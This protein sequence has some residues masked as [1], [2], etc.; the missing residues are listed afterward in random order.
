MTVDILDLDRQFKSILTSRDGISCFTKRSIFKEGCTSWYA[1]LEKR[2]TALINL[3]EMERNYDY[4]FYILETWKLIELYEK[5]LEKPLKKIFGKKSNDISRDRDDVAKK[6]LELVTRLVI[7]D[8]YPK[9]FDK[10]TY[11]NTDIFE[12]SRCKSADLEFDKECDAFMACSK[13]G[14]R[15]EYSNIKVTYIDPKRTNMCQRSANDKKSHFINCFNQWAGIQKITISQDILE[16]IEAKLDKYGALNKTASTRAEKFCRVTKDHIKI[17][18]K[19]L[20]LY[21]THSENITSIY[22]IITERYIQDLEIIRDK[23]LQDFDI[24]NDLYNRR[25]SAECSKPF[26]YQHLLFQFLRRHGF[27]CDYKDFKFLKT[28][29]RKKIHEEMYKDI[30]SEL[31]WNYVSMF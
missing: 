15:Q 11:T 23:V 16:S 9:R 10:I 2:E 5:E 22:R 28:T 18:L 20:N 6:Y 4:D 27:A 17:V 3:F 26:K 19:D 13:C 7:S 14:F 29:E 30:F 25:Y 31:K 24:F 8:I 1:F 12:C 21:K